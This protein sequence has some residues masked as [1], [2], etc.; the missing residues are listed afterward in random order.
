MLSL[1]VIKSLNGVFGRLY[2]VFVSFIQCI[3]IFDFIY[4]NTLFAMK[5]PRI[6]LYV[7]LNDD[8]NHVEMHCFCYISMCLTGICTLLSFPRKIVDL[9]KV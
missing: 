1:H 5:I 6:L 8:L 2:S 4:S 7:C 3:S 9:D